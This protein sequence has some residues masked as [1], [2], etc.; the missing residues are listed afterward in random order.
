MAR[1]RFTERI[2]VERPS[3]DVRVQDTVSLKEACDLLGIT[4]QSMN[5]LLRRSIAEPGKFVLR[6]FVDL[7]KDNPTQRNR[8]LRADVEK[9]LVRRRGRKGDARLKKKG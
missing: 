5:G 7:S 4:E 2:V 1:S 6:W 9:E 3:P 8:V